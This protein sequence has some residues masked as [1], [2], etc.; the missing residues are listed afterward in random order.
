MR[1][2]CVFVRETRESV[3]V[4]V[5]VVLCACVVEASVMLCYAE[6]M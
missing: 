4:V 6:L 1:H 2:L 3:S 5:T